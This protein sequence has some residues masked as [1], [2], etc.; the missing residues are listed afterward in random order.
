MYSWFILLYY[1]K[2]EKCHQRH[3][4]KASIKYE[5]NQD[6]YEHNKASPL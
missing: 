5:T 2:R 3:V 4:Y 6:N 1:V